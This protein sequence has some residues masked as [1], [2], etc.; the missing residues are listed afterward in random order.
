MG[1]LDRIERE[2]RSRRSELHLTPSEAAV[3]LAALVSG[4]S[5]GCATNSDVEA[6]RIELDST[7]K[8]AQAAQRPQGRMV[9]FSAEHY[10]DPGFEV[11]CHDQRQHKGDDRH[12]A[13]VLAPGR[14]DRAAL[15]AGRVLALLALDGEV[16]LPLGRDGVAFVVGIRVVE[17]DAA[18]L[19]HL[20]H[21]DPLDGVVSGGNILPGIS[22]C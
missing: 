4:S 7:R 20:E 10:H 12:D 13:V 14:A 9:L 11:R 19:V 6:L 18:V 17:I 8:I 2:R 5:L 21:A 1:L 16:A 3:A 22:A 15:H